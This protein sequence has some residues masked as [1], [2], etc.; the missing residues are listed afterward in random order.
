MPLNKQTKLDKKDLPLMLKKLVGLLL[1]AVAMV[2][3]AEPLPPSAGQVLREQ[4]RALPDLRLPA[5]GP[6][7]RNN[8][9]PLALDESG[10]LRLAQVRFVGNRSLSDAQ[11]TASLAPYIGRRASVADLYNL[12]G[13]VTNTYLEAG[14]LATVTLPEQDVTAGQVQFNVV[15]ALFAGPTIAVQGEQ[16]ALA[17][18]VAELVER[19]QPRGEVVQLAAL[20]RGQ[21]LA[22]DLDGVVLRSALDAGLLEGTTILLGELELQPGFSGRLVVDNAGS[23][24]TGTNRAIAAVDWVQPAERLNKVSALLLANDGSEYARLSAQWLPN[25][26]DGQ[27]HGSISQV[28]Y[29]VITPQ[30][31]EQRPRGSALNFSAGYRYPLVR[32]RARNDFLQLSLQHKRF[33]NRQRVGAG[34]Q[35]QSD[36]QLD[37]FN[38]EFSGN[39]YWR[40][41]VVEY[42]L[43]TTLGEVGLDKSPNQAA[44]LAGANSDG[45]YAVLLAGASLGYPLADKLTLRASLKGQLASGNL[46]ASERFYLGGSDGV[47]AYPESEGGGSQGFLVALEIERRLTER[48]TLALFFDLGQVQ[49]YKFNR[50]SQANLLAETNRYSLKGVGL[51]S[52]FDLFASSYMEVA[53]AKRMGSNPNATVDG[54][55]QD[56]SR[57]G[58]R[59]WLSLVVPF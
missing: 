39:R 43:R 20:E 29:E 47:R 33:D 10:L 17:K 41:G 48:A 24:G 59:A 13:V 32:S 8:E 26:N 34:Y 31:A 11:L 27:W 40:S 7:Q 30:F 14:Y 55:D 21:L 15:E 44:D 25:G 19:Q 45:S 9:S 57:A 46:D 1:L 2:A 54:R 36:Y 18:R 12:L 23:R 51:A 28:N 37:S 6:Y 35:A 56:G 3:A 42:T 49:Q 4:E 58:N 52:R 50:D 22:N 5:L 16:T 53:V 38:L